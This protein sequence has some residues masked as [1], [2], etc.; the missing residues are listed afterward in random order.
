MV[1]ELEILRLSMNELIKEVTQCRVCLNK[2][3]KLVLDLGSTPPANSFLLKEQLEDKELFFPLKVNFCPNC[4]QLQLSHSVSPDLLFKNYLYVSSTSPIFIKH[5]EDYALQVY[6]NYKLNKNSLIIDLGSNDG[7]LLKPFKTLGCKV[8][9]V[10][11]AEEIANKATDAG[12]ETVP[13]FFNSKTAKEILNKYGS[14]DI[15]TANNVFAHVPEIDELIKGVQILLAPEGVFIV[16]FPYLIDFIQKNLFDLVYHEHVSYF[17]VRP[18]VKLFERFDMQIIDVMKVSSHGGSIRVF[19]KK[20]SSNRPIQPS[21]KKFIKKEKDLGLDDIKT[22]YKFAER[23]E[24][25]KKELRILL[26]KLKAL[27]KKIVGYGAPAKG[28]TLLNYFGIDNKVLNYIIDDSPLKQGLYT[29]G[30]HIPVVSSEVLKKA[31]PDYLFILAWNFA[32]PIMEK[33]KWVQDRGTKFI[34]PV[35]SP[36]VL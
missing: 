28:N 8:L 23:I 33:Y 10:D 34:V 22:Y 27:N 1:S 36:K 18:L 14:A 35:P 3:L 20:K 30:T 2:D 13:A 7:I 21:V 4:G 25:N 12:L 11:P 26:L 32:E 15:I 19:I 31:L 5:F 24:N 6:H 16:E 29:P 17:S 9:G